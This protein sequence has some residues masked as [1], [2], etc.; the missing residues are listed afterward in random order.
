MGYDNKIT[1]SHTLHV[2]N[3]EC[4]CSPQANIP[5]LFTRYGTALCRLPDGKYSNFNEN[6]ERS[7]YQSNMI[8]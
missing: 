1:G 6:R 4:I 5:T 2:N 3:F 8:R 7:N